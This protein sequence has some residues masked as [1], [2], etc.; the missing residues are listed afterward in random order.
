MREIGFKR[1]GMFEKRVLRPS[2]VRL[3]LVRDEEADGAFARVVDDER[4]V[5]VPEEA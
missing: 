1:P 2:E 4:A 5:L 3:D